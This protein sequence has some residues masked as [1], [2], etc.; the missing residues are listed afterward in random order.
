[1]ERLEKENEHNMLEA[2][3]GRHF[4]SLFE[5]QQ[6]EMDMKNNHLKQ[7]KDHIEEISMHNTLLTNHVEFQFKEITSLKSKLKATV[8]MH[9]YQAS[10]KRKIGKVTTHT[11]SKPST[12]RPHPRQ[13]KESNEWASPRY[14]M[15]IV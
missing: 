7:A 14:M 6:K 10:K 1:M 5:Q 4:R 3:A 2:C 8:Q 11:A 15:S 9:A 12:P 13:M